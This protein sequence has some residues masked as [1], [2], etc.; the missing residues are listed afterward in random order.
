MVHPAVRQL[1]QRVRR[2]CRKQRMSRTAFG[3]Q[4]LNDGKLI[5]RLEAG[6]EISHARVDKI[7]KFMD[8]VTRQRKKLSTTTRKLTRSRQA[9]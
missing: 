5:P 2:F 8:R 4:A 6:R 3:L 9:E 7:K 1:L